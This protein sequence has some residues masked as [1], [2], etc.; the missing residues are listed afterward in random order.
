MSRELEILHR[1]GLFTS[2]ILVS[3]CLA[4]SA[5]GGGGGGVTS[6]PPPPPPPPPETTATVDVKTSWLNSPATRP[7]NYDLIGRLTLNGD[8]SGSHP[9]APGSFFFE[10]ARSFYDDPMTYQLLAPAGIL[11]GGLTSAELIAY[12]DSWT[13][14]LDPP[15][16][17]RDDYPF[18]GDYVQYFG[19]RF[20]AY[21]KP[22]DG[23]A[24]TELFSFDLTRDTSVGYE[25]FGTKQLKSTLDYDLGYSYVAMGE[26]SWQVLDANGNPA[27]DSGSLLFVNGDR[28]PPS[29]IPLSGKASYDARTL[30]ATSSSIPFQLTADFGERSIATEISQAAKFDVS[31]SAPFS[32]D[33][34]FDILLT[35]TA[36]A[37]AATGTM[38]GAFFGPHA[39]QVGG[40][41]AVGTAGGNVVAQDA[42]VGQQH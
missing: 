5:C 13:I 1:R 16:W 26:W 9:I 33:G 19:Q 30:G 7:G 11:P 24:E 35:G 25:A 39:E 27:G 32:N 41:F 18:G 17:R 2:L 15:S 40:T 8:V 29:G 38:N 42:F 34:S 10:V 22:A 36:G 23:G 31:G 4:L 12:G 6:I 20:T 37:Q 3:F 28:T 21:S 14:S